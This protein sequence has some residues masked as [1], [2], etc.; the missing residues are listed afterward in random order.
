V[1]GVFVNAEQ[2]EGGVVGVAT[3]CFWL[4]SEN[5]EQSNNGMCRSK[6]DMQLRCSD[7]R[8]SSQCLSTS[9][10]ILDAECVWIIAE[11]GEE[12]QH[13]RSSCEDI[14]RG[15]AT[16]NYKGAAKSGADTLSCLWVAEAITK[17][18]EVKS[19]CSFLETEPVCETPGAAVAD[20]NESPLIC[21]WITSDGKNGECKEKV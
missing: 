9:V 18:Q 7:L 10:D 20:G 2:C 8:R 3:N 12:C 11:A 5:N 17:C 16:C 4:L 14:T 13:V 1:C 6:N 15:S 21:A 19:A